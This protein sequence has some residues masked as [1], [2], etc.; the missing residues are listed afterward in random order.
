MRS[1]KNV[2]TPKTDVKLASGKVVRLTETQRRVA[3]HI[4]ETGAR[5]RATALA[6][7]LPTQ[8]VYSVLKQ[9][10]VR[11][12]MAER[13]SEAIGIGAAR[14]INVLLDLLD[15]KSGYVRLQAAQDILDRAGY[16]P[17]Q[18]Q[19]IAVKGEFTFTVDLG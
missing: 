4:A 3:D 8:T 5:G 9:Q 18:K 19:A 15:H 14:A 2:A 10:H 16:A 11:D 7:E 6:L 12:Y 13:V 1:R 17:V